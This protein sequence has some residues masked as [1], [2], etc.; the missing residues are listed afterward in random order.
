MEQTSEDHVTAVDVGTRDEIERVE[1]WRQEELERA[2][3][4]PEAANELAQRHD[5]DLHAAV[6]LL[7][8]GCPPEIALQ[9]LL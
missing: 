8:R 1:A 4:S 6:G 3:F 5:V 9:I 7:A 2:G